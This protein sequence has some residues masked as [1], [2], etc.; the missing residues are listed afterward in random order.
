[1]QEEE[2]KEVDTFEPYSKITKYIR[3]LCE[4]VWG[5]K[6][7]FFLLVHL[8]FWLKRLVVCRAGYW[9]T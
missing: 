3:E 6:H 2:I 9:V 1:M 5:Q 4:T 8:R 7:I